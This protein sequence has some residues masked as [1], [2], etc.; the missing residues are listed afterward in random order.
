MKQ[1]T[2]ILLLICTISAFGQSDTT[3]IRSLINSNFPDNT[4]N[5]ITPARLRTVSL[6]LMRSSANLAEENT[7]LESISVEDSIKSDVGF[8]VWNGVAYEE[9]GMGGFWEVI[10]DTLRLNTPVD[11]YSISS[12]SGDT[13]ATIYMKKVNNKFSV[14]LGVTTPSGPIAVNV[15]ANRIDIAGSNQVFS[16]QTVT[17]NA[18]DSVV[19][20]SNLGVESGQFTEVDTVASGSTV[21]FGTANNIVI[22]GTA[23]IDSISVASGTRN[24]Q[25]L[26]IEF[27]GTAATN[28]LVDGGNILLS[29]DYGYLPSAIITLQRRGNYFYEVSRSNNGGL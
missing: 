4:S 10:S 8:Y 22:T 19:I 27:T 24:W 2:T 17:M 15:S 14:G 28:G 16:A 13:T 5:Y 25:V 23:D 7:F 11:G 12:T 26:T 1:I 9:I 20:S 29:S 21:Q 6:E 3:A 18:Q